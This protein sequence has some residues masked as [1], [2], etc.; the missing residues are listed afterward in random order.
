MRKLSP[1]INKWPFLLFPRQ[2]TQIKS[3]SVELADH[4]ANVP[5]DDTVDME[6][7]TSI[8]IL[9]KSLACINA[10][11]LVNGQNGSGNNSCSSRHSGVNVA[12]AE[13]AFGL[14]GRMT[15]DA[16]KQVVSAHCGYLNTW[17]T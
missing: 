17:A 6:L 12:L 9:F 10:S 8:E 2:R 4:C 15:N 1:V 5:K 14:L 11:F 3:L 7:M 16:L 13:R